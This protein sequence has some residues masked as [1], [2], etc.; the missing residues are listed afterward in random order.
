V[1]ISSMF[2]FWHG[3]RAN[4]RLIASLSTLLTSVLASY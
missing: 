2:G 4:V 3:F 1:S